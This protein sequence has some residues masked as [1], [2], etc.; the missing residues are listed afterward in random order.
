MLLW[1]GCSRGK[2]GAREPFAGGGGQAWS[3]DGSLGS[4]GARPGVPTMTLFLGLCATRGRSTESVSGLAK[5]EHGQKSRL[6]DPRSTFQMR[7]ASL[8]DSD[9]IV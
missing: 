6:P 3:W 4:L 7:N 8:E 1:G 2:H 5:A 9:M